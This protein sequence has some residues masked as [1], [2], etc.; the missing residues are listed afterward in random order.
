M[1]DEAPVANAQ[2]FQALIAHNMSQPAEEAP[3]AK[4]ESKQQQAKPKIPIDHGVDK[5]DT[6]PDT[7]LDTDDDASR[8]LSALAE[9]EDGT[10]VA[11][12]IEDDESEATDGQDDIIHGMSSKEIIDG[13]KKGEVPAGLLDKLK[14]NVTVDGQNSLVSVDE[15]R[16]GY[17]RMSHYTQGR[18][19]AKEAVAQAQSQIDN[20]RKMFEGWNSGDALI[21]GLKRLGKL[22]VLHQAA[23]IHAKEQYKMT[24]LQRENP[25]AYEAMIAARAAQEKLEEYETREKNRPDESQQ[26]RVRTLG[27]KLTKLVFPAFDSNKIKDTPVARRLF[28]ENFQTLYDGDEESLETA[29]HDAAVATAEQLTE[30]ALQHQAKLRENGGDPKK[31]K[32][33]PPVLGSKAPATVAPKKT[34]DKKS[35]SV[36]DMADFLKKR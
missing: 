23:I 2:N 27:E 26:E 16:K 31:G 30:M 6:S 21:R 13:I 17:M 4:T 22:D 10:E 15:A 7:A 19:Q 20:V 36:S 35:M 8:G 11:D 12:P 14:V 32:P 9:A 18:Q 34:I 5:G 29:V 33:T 3:A 1:A 28:K 24:K 25:Q